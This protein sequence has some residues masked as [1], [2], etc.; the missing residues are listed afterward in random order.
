MPE[1]TSQERTEEATPHRRE[2]AIEKGDVVHSREIVTAAV[3]FAAVMCIPL[4]QGLFISTGERAFHAFFRFHE[5]AVTDVAG[6]RLVLL[7]MTAIMAPI[8][9][10]VFAIVMVVG[11]AANVAQVGWVV[12]SKK[13]EMKPERLSPAKGFE[14]LFGRRSIAEA[15]RTL[16]KFLIVGLV[17]YVTVRAR[18]DDLLQL[19]AVAVQDFI[20]LLGSLLWSLAWRVAVLMGVFAVFDYGYQRWDWSRRLRMSRQELKEEIKEREGNPLVKQRIRALQSEQ[21]RRRMMADVPKAT[22]VIVNPTRRSSRRSPKS[23]PTFSA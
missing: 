19:N 2:Q 9:I 17:S 16:A 6:L 11:V 3:V 15:V 5:F 12:S 1:E 4:V 14:R 23:S 8:L 13:L 7:Q 20:P 18:F 22:A 21:A 10:P